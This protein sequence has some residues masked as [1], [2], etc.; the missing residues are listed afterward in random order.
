M[1]ATELI[2]FWIARLEAEQARLIETGQDVPAMA[3]QG[4]LVRTTSSLQAPQRVPF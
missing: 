4:R 2:E 3:S 1:T